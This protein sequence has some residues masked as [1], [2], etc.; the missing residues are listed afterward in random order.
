M[1]RLSL[2][3]AAGLTGALFVLSL[4]MVGAQAS[5]ARL[6]PGV[7]VE[8]KSLSSAVVWYGGYRKY[9]FSTSDQA[10][11]SDYLGSGGRLLV[12]GQ[13]LAE[14]LRSTAFLSETLHVRFLRNTPWGELPIS[15]LAGDILEGVSSSFTYGG[16]DVL[17][18]ADALSVPIAEYSGADTGVAG[19]RVMDGGHPLPLSGSERG[20]G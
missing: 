15:G 1:K 10:A 14:G 13:R 17:E 16:E 3:C 20:R 5:P 4:L 19:L 8:P 18:P 2:F 6:Q 9:G 7:A 11:I 12:T